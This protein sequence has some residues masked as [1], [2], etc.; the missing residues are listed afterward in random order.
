MAA[1]R[2]R[3]T[4]PAVIPAASTRMVATVESSVA[5]MAVGRPPQK[6]MSGE[7]SSRMAAAMNPPAKKG[8]ALL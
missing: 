7:T 8:D 6:A 4:A 5:A 2:L 1:A 3:K